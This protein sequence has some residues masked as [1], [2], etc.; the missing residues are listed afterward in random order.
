MEHTNANASIPEVK[1]TSETPRPQKANPAK[2]KTRSM[3]ELYP[4]SPKSMTDK[5]KNRCIEEYRKTINL[6][7][8]RDK[9]LS[10]NCKEAY[11]KF[12]EADAECKRV[13][14]EANA[15]LAFCKQT[16][17]VCY[18]TV[19]MLESKNVKEK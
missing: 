17:E 16:V 15:K 6:L 1:E 4:L 7:V 14:N 3:D 9:F 18:K 13:T 2:E 11:E 12:K 10:E 8:E 19:A 5:E